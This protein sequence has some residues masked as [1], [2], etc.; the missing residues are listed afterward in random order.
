MFKFQYAAPV[1]L[2]LLAA[3]QNGSVSE[4]LKPEGYVGLRDGVSGEITGSIKPV[5]ASTVPAAGF[6]QD[7]KGGNSVIKNYHPPKVGT[8]FG[9][10]NNWVSLESKLV[11][12][13]ASLDEKFNTKSAMRFESIEGTGNGVNSYFDLESANLVGHKDKSGTPLVTYQKIE[14]RLKF[15]MRPGDKWMTDWKFFDHKT[16]KT[17]S[18]KGMVKAIGID[19]LQTDAGRFKTMK[20]K[21]PSPKGTGKGMSHFI[22]YSPKL[23]VVVREQISSKQFSWVKEIERVEI[24]KG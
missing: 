19:Q 13:V 11:Y 3:C 8:I 9:W 16:Q 20:I 6:S 4:T 17:Q 14:N 23:G 1:L 7:G 18:G 12:R 24:P 5:V 15:P 10:R 21:L 2:L 22:W